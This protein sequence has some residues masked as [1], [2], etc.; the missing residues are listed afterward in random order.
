M[1]TAI[2]L[3][4][5]LHHSPLDFTMNDI[6]GK[7][8]K[9]ETY[10]NKLIMMVNVAS[11]CGYT[12]QYA[13]LQTVYEKYKSKGLVILGFPANEFGEQEPG[14]NAEIKAFCTG[15]YHVTFPMFSKI[16]VNGEGTHPL[17]KFLT[18]KET[19]GAFAGP[20]KWNFTKFLIGKNGQVIARFEPKIKPTDTQVIKM[21][22]HA[23]G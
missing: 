9:L 7:P 8:V 11:Q 17:Y 15:N 23:L 12:P 5:M 4:A 21:I 14:T 19:G 6:D 2:I 13:D 10:K 22:E 3:S 20:I 16:V 18:E 1:I